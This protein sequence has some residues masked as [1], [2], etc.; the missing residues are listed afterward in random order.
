MPSGVERIDLPNDH[1]LAPG[2]VDL[3]VNGGGGVLFTTRPMRPPLRR[4]A[5]AHAHA[6][7]TAL[8]PTLISG[9]RPQLVPRRGGARGARGGVA[10]IAGLHL[11]GPFI[12]AARRGI[13][14]ADAVSTMTDDDLRC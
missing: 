9:T 3:Q 11:E 12:A 7:T 6:G 14:P 5:A 10:G 13:H 8:L 2:F 4:I 1:V